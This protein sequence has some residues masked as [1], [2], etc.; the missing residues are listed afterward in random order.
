MGAPPY[1]QFQKLTKKFGDNLVLD[2]IDLDF[3]F[4]E[5]TGVIGTSGSGKTTMLNLLVGFIKPSSGKIL[6]QSRDIFKDMKNIQT[7][8]GFGTQSFSFYDDLTVDEN[9]KYFGK[10]YHLNK[11]FV[12]KR[13][14]ELLDLV[15]LTYARKTL[16]GRLS[17]GMGRRL[18]IAC[19]LI[20]SPKILILD[21]PTQDLDVLL[22]RDLIKTIKKI[23]KSGTTVIITSHLLD[24]MDDLCD[25]IA[26]LNNHTIVEFGTP[27]QIKKKYKK[28]NLD[29]AFE[30]IMQK[31]K[32]EIKEEKVVEGKRPVVKKKKVVNNKEKEEKKGDYG[33][34]LNDLEIMKL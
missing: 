23:K 3:P 6:F 21:E 7:I 14:D 5:I 26:I 16:A 13:M 28:K 2:D 10:L 31:G 32:K 18:D 15:E 24:E 1:I 25:K 8:F 20:H 19:A 30:T 9:L 4:G 17:S 27:A 12:N 29:D 22:R 33:Q 34:V 11:D